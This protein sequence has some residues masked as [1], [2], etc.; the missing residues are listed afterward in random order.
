MVHG[1]T[2]GNIVTIG[3]PNVQIVS[4]TYGE[5]DGISTLQMGLSMV[6]GSGGNDEFTIAVT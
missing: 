2:A 1:T 5:S 3:A 6:P 4:P